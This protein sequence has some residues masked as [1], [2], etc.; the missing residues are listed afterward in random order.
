[1][2]Q[3]KHSG[4]GIAVAFATALFFNFSAKSFSRKAVRKF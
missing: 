4:K 1:M 2:K 3:E